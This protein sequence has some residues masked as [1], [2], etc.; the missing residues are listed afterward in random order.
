MGYEY[1]KNVFIVG[2]CLCTFKVYWCHD[3]TY[4][5]SL[6]SFSVFMKMASVKE[7]V[8]RGCHDSNSK[9]IFFPIKGNLNLIIDFCNKK[10]SM[11]IL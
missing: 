7:N 5:S 2:L 10:L 3:W 11:T 1:N 8:H 6:I 4:K 9:E